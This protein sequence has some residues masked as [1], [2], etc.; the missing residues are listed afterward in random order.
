MVTPLSGESKNCLVCLNSFSISQSEK[1]FIIKVSPTFGTQKIEIPLPTLCPKCRQKRRICFRSERS[2]YKRKCDATGK[3]MISIYSPLSKHTVYH[4]EYWWNAQWDP[5]TFSETFNF[6]KP[7]F[8]QFESLYR[9][10]PQMSLLVIG[11]E[12]CEFTNMTARSQNCYLTFGAG[13]NKDCAYCRWLIHNEAL[14]DCN[15]ATECTNLYECIDSVNL[16]NSFYCIGCSDSS[17]CYGCYDLSACHFCIGC[18]NLRNKS[19]CINNVQLTKEEFFQ[20]KEKIE[21]TKSLLLQTYENAFHRNVNNFH[22]E[23]VSGDYIVHSKNIVHG[24]DVKDAENC[25]YISNVD[26][27]DNCQHI[28][29]QA[30]H[31]SFCYESIAFETC[32]SILFSFV[33]VWGKNMI[34]CISCFDCHNCFWCVW[35]RNKEYCVFNTQYSKEE[36]E[37][38]VPKIIETMKKYWEWWEFFPP[39]LSAFG[40]NET[41]A[42]EYFPMTKNEVFSSVILSEQS[43][44]KYPLNEAI[45]KKQSIRDSSLCSEW[46]K[47]KNTFFHWPIF[48]WSDYEQVFPKVVKIIPANKLPKD[49]SQI[50]DDI[51]SWAIECEETKKP[52]R[53]TPLELSFYKKNNIGIPLKHPDIRHKERM[54]LRNPRKL[55]NRQC[56]ECYNQIETTYA[57]ERKEKVLCETCYEKKVY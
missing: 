35:L 47:Q 4:H 9:K 49:I 13:D 52:F 2:L 44:S 42:Q 33:F 43:E 1:D 20:Q 6:E 21:I 39:S 18:S 48:N 19:Y 29:F 3:E 40:Y 54:N 45:S 15:N 28:D 31:G 24:F 7:F 56:D 25:R 10:V 11:N 55:W 50:P 41:I 30:E 36:Y 17:D 12:N 51:L 32:S 14:I 16:S 22:S 46:Q 34:Y 37:T 5:L 26:K 53:I 57:P 23:N 38:L 8:P 27:I